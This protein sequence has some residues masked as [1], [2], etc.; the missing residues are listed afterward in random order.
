M[1]RIRF[2]LSSLLWLV[3]CCA[4][5]LGWWI[6]RSGFPPKPP[7]R[8]PPVG[9]VLDPDRVESM[10]ATLL[11][12]PYGWDLPVKEKKV[13][14]AW[15]RVILESFGPF[16][17]DEEGTADDYWRIGLLEITLRDGRSVNL[18]WYD[19]GQ[20]S[21][22]F[23][24]AGVLY[25]RSEH[26]QPNAETMGSDEGAYLMQLIEAAFDPEMAKFLDQGRRDYGKSPLPGIVREP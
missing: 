6:D 4:L 15:H 21:L 23:S 13:P 20:H 11:Y 17:V 5:A 1:R 26:F 25:R 10:R 14:I 3:L 9:A 19:A 16:I 12:S 7:R 8:A 24:Y 22:R 2:R 18:H